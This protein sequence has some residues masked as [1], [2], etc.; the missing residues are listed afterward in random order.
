MYPTYGKHLM[1][2]KYTELINIKDSANMNRE[3]KKNSRDCHSI[4]LSSWRCCTISTLLLKTVNL[5]KKEC[6]FLISL[7]PQSD[8]S[9]NHIVQ[10]ELSKLE[11]RSAESLFSVTTFPHNKVIDTAVLIL[12]QL[13]C[14]RVLSTPSNPRSKCCIEQIFLHLVFLLNLPKSTRHPLL[15]RQNIRSYFQ[16]SKVRKKKIQLFF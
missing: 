13:G 16:F 5:L 10:N 14:K 6:C 8:W 2:H 7:V 15:Q 3:K 4:F 11:F 9:L 1:Y 12:S